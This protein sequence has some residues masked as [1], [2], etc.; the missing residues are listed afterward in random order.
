MTMMRRA[1]YPGSFDPFTNGHLDVLRQS[2]RIFDEVI[3]AILKNPG[4]QSLFT[5]E[6]RV[7]MIQKATDGIGG[8]IVE[9]FMGLLADYMKLKQADAIVRGLRDSSDFENELR[10]AQMN[11]SL[12]ENACT[13]FIPTSHAY[14]FVS[15]SLVKDIAMHGG[16]IESFVPVHIAKEMLKRYSVNHN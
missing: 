3:V 16:N 10:M 2:S 12:N 15:S 4:K 13:I 6:E 5:V 8:V 11:R 9:S 1:V 14:G 7:A